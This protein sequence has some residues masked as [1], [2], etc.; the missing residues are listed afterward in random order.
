MLS[1]LRV[2]SVT[3]VSDPKPAGMF[4]WLEKISNKESEQ[5]N[6]CQRWGVERAVGL[7]LLAPI[8]YLKKLEV[9]ILKWWS[10]S[11]APIFCQ[12]HGKGIEEQGLLCKGGHIRQ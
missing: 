4:I 11:L 5:R 8:E 3:L 2:S 9:H 6:V 12:N 10:H 7:N 1:G